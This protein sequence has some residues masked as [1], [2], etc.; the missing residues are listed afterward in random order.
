MAVQHP[1]E[2]LLLPLLMQLAVQAPVL[3]TYL[4]GAIVA[5]ILARRAPGPCLLTLAAMVLMLLTALAQG[6]AQ[7]WLTR[8][9]NDLQWGPSQLGTWFSIIA[10]VGS[11]IRAVAV[12]LLLTAVFLGCRS[13]SRT[14]DV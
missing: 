7:V 12:S 10:F 4:I 2:T 3:L 9:R 14:V 6:F 5:L 1:F 11:A 8:A 13:P